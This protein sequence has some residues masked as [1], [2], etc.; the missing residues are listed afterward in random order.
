MFSPYKAV[1]D[2][3]SRRLRIWLD[4]RQPQTH[5]EVLS[6]KNLYI[7]PSS[8]FPGFLLVIGMIW[9]AGTNYENNLVLALAFF[10]LAIFVSTIFTTH[11]NLSGLEIAIAGH[12]PVFAGEPIHIHLKIENPTDEDR[13]RVMFI[14]NN[15]EVVGVDVPARSCAETSIQ[16][17]TERRGRFQPERIKV[18]TT[19]P[20]G[21]LRAWSWPKLKVDA[22]VYP[23]PVAAEPAGGDQSEGGEGQTH[24]R[25][26]DD[27]GGLEEW[28]PGIPAQR[29][30]WKQYSAGRGLLE[31][32]FE[33]QTL[34]PQWLDWEHYAGMGIE[35]RLSAICDKA[36]GMERSGQH[37][38]LR[39]PGV[40]YP[41]SQGD[42]HLHKVLTALA[43]YGEDSSTLSNFGSDPATVSA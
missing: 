17:P 31:K 25:G 43:A 30:A 2:R 38:G 27:F 15:A 4:R 35:E 32:S 40:M 14:W 26:I 23:R 19:Y 13:M 6:Q 33:A 37:Y 12:E 22:L 21:I 41:P 36:L 8:Q 1:R 7:F 9:I 34:N 29:I 24:K 39:L 28:R 10:M 11:A 3:L 20:L 42:S 18:Q 5:R 16:L